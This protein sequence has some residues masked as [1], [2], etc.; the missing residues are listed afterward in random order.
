[1]Y[2]VDYWLVLLMNDF[3]MLLVN[4]WLVNFCDFFFMNYWLK[5][6]VDHL[7]VMLMNHILMVLMNN[8]LMMFNDHIFVVLFDNRLVNVSLHSHWFGMRLHLCWKCVL[9]EGS[10]LF[11]LDDSWCLFE[12]S[13]NDGFLSHSFCDDWSSPACKCGFL[14][15]LQFK[16]LLFCKLL[17]C[18]LV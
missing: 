16:P 10:L 14:S 8:I 17:S 1:M 12:C 9:L 13:L 5:V 2:L 11:V 6:L 4:Y 15:L 7:L 18:W 3:G